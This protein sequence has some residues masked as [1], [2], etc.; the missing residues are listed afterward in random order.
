MC[1]YYDTRGPTI[2]HLPEVSDLLEY[3]FESLSETNKSLGPNLIQVNSSDKF[4]EYRMQYNV[5][6][7]RKSDT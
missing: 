3:C 2:F 6:M 4:F 1:E 5:T 7:I